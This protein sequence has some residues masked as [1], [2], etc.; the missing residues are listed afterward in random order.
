MKKKCSLCKKS[1]SIEEFRKQNDRKS[2]VSSIC[3]YCKRIKE[4]SWRERNKKQRNADQRTYYFEH[5][6]EIAEKRK[7]NYDPIKGKARWMARKIAEQKCIFCD[8][9]G[10][11]HHEDYKH[12]LDIVFLC[13]SHHKQI[14]DGTMYL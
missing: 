9:K 2:G 8:K 5:K 11:R 14:H 6:K 12:P 7:R 1:Y 3:V 4:A 13:K 10:E